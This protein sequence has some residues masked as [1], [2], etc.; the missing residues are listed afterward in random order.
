MNALGPQGTL[1]QVLGGPGGVD[2]LNSMIRDGVV[3]QQEVAALKA[4][5]TLTEAGKARISQALTGRF[6]ADTEQMAATVLPVRTRIERIAGPLTDLDADPKWTLTPTVQGAL[7]Q[8]REASANKNTLAHFVKTGNIF[9]RPGYSPRVIEM[10]KTLQSAPLPEL[11]DAAE[12]YAQDAAADGAPE[13]MFGKPAVP[14]PADA[15]T[16]ALNVAKLNAQE[17]KLVATMRKLGETADDELSEAGKATRESKLEAA[18][19]AL[20]DVRAKRAAL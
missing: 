20:V 18:R 6:Y 1:P 7:E 10:A 12:I 14:E 9:G 15:F 3:N 4:G 5:N 19:Q 13:G 11:K 2:V 16:R 17:S 8:L